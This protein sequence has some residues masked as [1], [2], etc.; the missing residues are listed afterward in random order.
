MEHLRY[1]IGK[2]VPKESYSADE[3][4]Q[5]ISDI[6][7]FPEKL[8]EELK[9]LSASSLQ[10]KYRPEGWTIRQLIHHCADS[11]LNS[12]PR[13]KLAL[14]E[15]NPTIR[16]YLENRWA[17]LADIES[18]VSLSID[19]LTALHAKWVYLIK[20]FS[21]EDLKKT[22]VHPEHNKTFTLAQ[23]IALYSWHG[24]HHLEHIR[25]AKANKF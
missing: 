16:P 20:R 5:L 11:H 18:P 8:K 25:L 17:E 12:V 7:V 23:T 14:T 24:R 3:Q 4:A 22:Y 9:A 15:K 13:F 1:P 6:E 21:S 19:L 2:Y 10:W